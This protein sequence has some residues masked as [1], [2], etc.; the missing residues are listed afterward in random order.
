MAQP[1]DGWL[2]GKA[3]ES[4]VEVMDGVAALSC[5]EKDGFVEVSLHGENNHTEKARYVIDCEGVVGALKR[6]I[7][8]EV[9]GYI[10]T[11]QTFNEG[12]ID[13]D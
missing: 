9:P 1:F 12:S 6:K 4:G 3:K 8:G 5:T 11:Y 13:L 10:T 2:A 7:T